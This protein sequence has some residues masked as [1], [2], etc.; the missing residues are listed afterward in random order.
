MKALK[1]VFILP[2]LFFM[3][4]LVFAD[5][6]K[7]LIRQAGQAEQY[8]SKICKSEEI[9]CQMSVEAYSGKEHKK[10]DIGIDVSNRAA[11]IFFKMND[12]FLSNQT[13]KH[14]FKIGVP[15]AQVITQEIDLFH[16][17]PSYKKD[18]AENLVLRNMG[19]KIVTLEVSL[20]NV[21]DNVVE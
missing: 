16:L 10:I 7:V 8:Y 9:L 1:S 20:K 13:G 3:P 5:D 17:H 2:H 19:D 14:Y 11:D 21:S 15:V 4:Q 12:E 18:T 6:Y